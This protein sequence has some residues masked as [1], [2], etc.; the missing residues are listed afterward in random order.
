MK[1]NV[2]GAFTEHSAGIGMVLWDSQGKV[3]FSVCR[4]LQHCRDATEAEL[5]AVEEGLHIALHWTQLGLTVETDCAESVELIME[6]T[7]NTSMFAFKVKF[8]S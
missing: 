4:S 8:N 1:L 2:D 7:L 5:L 6:T 3:L